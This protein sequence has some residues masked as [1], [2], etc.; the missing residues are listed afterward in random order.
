M[1][2]MKKILASVLAMIVVISLAACSASAPAQA[3]PAPAAPSAPA[4]PAAPATPAA[5]AKPAAAAVKLKVA[6]VG[7]P[8]DSLV[9]LCETFKTEVEKQSTGA[10]VAEV[11]HTSQLGAHRD[12]IDGLQM[13]SIQ[14]AEIASSVVATIEP[15][16]MIFDLPYLVKDEKTEID[17]LD[18]K[19][20]QIL[21]EALV[22]K[23]NLKV[24]GW[25]VRSPRHVYSSKGAVKTAA[26][27]K[28]LKIRTMESAPMLRAMELLGAKATPI[29]SNERYMALQTKVVDAAENNC[30]EIYSK[31]EYEVTKY[32]SK[33]AHIIQPNVLC[34]DNK[35]LKTLSDA[36][37]KTIIKVGKE[38]GNL[39]TKF[40]LDNVSSI[41]SKLASEG[42]M[43]INEIADKSSFATLLTPLYDEYKDKIGQDLIGI[44][45]Q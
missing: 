2:N 15:K 20:G 6:T 30:G 39:A 17:A 23:A 11:F 5:P 13:G 22:A 32:L 34:M 41:E 42:K 3:A 10:I 36:D 25:L 16:F 40:D 27:F 33:T 19:A 38:A 45:R 31:K 35:F 28:G 8:G 7:S 37:Q 44:F 14:V 24:L 26:D 18:G 9:K 29:P 1:T 4:A 21:D 12:Y 43:A